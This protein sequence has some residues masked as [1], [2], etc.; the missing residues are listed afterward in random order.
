MAK[1]VYKALDISRF[2][3]FPHDMPKEYYKWLPK[4]I[5]N[6]VV[7]GLKLR[8]I[9]QFF[10]KNVVNMMNLKNRRCGLETVRRILG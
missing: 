6:N 2:P 4:L 3:E 10:M 8:S 1:D 5:G 7:K 9:S